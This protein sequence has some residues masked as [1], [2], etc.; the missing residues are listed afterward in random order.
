MEAGDVIP[1]DRTPVVHDLVQDQLD[2][3]GIDVL[4][5]EQEKGFQIIFLMREAK[6]KRQC[7]GDGPS[8]TTTWSIEQV[9]N[10]V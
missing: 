1:V 9:N 5:S 2:H 3:L 8:R 4:V 6:G 7:Y 10:T